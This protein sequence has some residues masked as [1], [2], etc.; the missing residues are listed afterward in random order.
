M[1]TCQ[2][3]TNVYFIFIFARYAVIVSVDQAGNR[4]VLDL[5]V[6]LVTQTLHFVRYPNHR[7]VV[8]HI[9]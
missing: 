6:A 5:S 1:H 3:K 7:R 9:D 2:P 4:C 8:N